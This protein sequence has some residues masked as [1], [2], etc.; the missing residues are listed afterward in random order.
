MLAASCEHVME[1]SHELLLIVLYFSV[2]KMCRPVVFVL[3][4]YVLRYVALSP[5]CRLLEN[6][7]ILDQY[8]RASHTYEREER[9]FTPA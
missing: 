4:T 5:S 2:E 9:R 3:S 7:A 8:E 6:S 1:Q